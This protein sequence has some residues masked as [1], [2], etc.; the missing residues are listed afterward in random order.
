MDLHEARSANYLRELFKAIPEDTIL[1]TLP[2]SPH[3]LSGKGRPPFPRKAM[4][5]ALVARQGLRIPSYAALALRLQQ[6]IVLR[7]ECGFVFGKGSPGEDCLEDFAHLLGTHTE[8]LGCG[9]DRQVDEL[10]FL[11][12]EFG[13]STSWDSA[14]I[15]LVKPPQQEVE[16]NE[17][18][19]GNHTAA[20]LDAPS[21]DESATA[22]PVPLGKESGTVSPEASS[23]DDGNGDGKRAEKQSTPCSKPEAASPRALEGDWG[24]KTYESVCEKVLELKDGTKVTGI[25]VKKET[26]TLFGGKIHLIVD[27]KYHLPIGIEVTPQSQGDCPMVPFMYREFCKNHPQ[28]EVRYAMADKAAD[29]AEVHQTLVEELGIIPLIPLREA[30]NREAPATPEY[31]FPKTV[32]DRERVTHL[33]DPRTGKY[34]EIEPWGY[35]RS[36]QAVKYR[37]P[38]ERMRKEGRLRADERCPFFGAQCGGS[39]D[40]FPYSFRVNLRENWRYYCPVPRE[41]DRWSEL[42]KQ[43]T[44]VE[45]VNALAKGPLQLG[46]K[47][48]RSLTTATA[49]AYLA[50]I[51]LCARAKVAIDWG[52]PEKVGSAVT[53]IPYRRHRMA[54]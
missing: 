11:L 13:E 30:P 52:A 29:S 48:L 26:N 8:A 41:T 46:D 27:N 1:T 28:I 2:P 10:S 47:R 39:R 44:T 9:F 53:E 42:Y 50:C 49:E 43:R 18:Q 24:K 23:P 16:E 12:P 22:P 5:R 6:D 54:G 51:V 4:L 34:E 31:E 45:R 3:E 7:H 37:C 14:H 35:D 19:E 38:C 21:A 32:Y 40:K 15:P 25:E 17:A 36:R 33:I 20:R